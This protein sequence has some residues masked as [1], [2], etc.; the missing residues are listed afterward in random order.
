[1][2]ALGRKLAHHLS[3][4]TKLVFAQPPLAAL[5]AEL[6]PYAFTVQVL[7][8]SREIDF[9]R[10]FGRG[11]IKTRLVIHGGMDLP[12]WMLRGHPRILNM[13][14]PIRAGDLS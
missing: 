13:S 3:E 14:R 12:E 6:S 11:H 5:P 2:F 10:K 9:E 7:A 4:V 1:M 8:H